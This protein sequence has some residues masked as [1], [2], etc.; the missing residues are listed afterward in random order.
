VQHQAEAVR[1][2]PQNRLFF[3]TIADQMPVDHKARTDLRSALISY[4]TVRNQRHITVRTSDP[5]R[6]HKK[7]EP[8]GFPPGSFVFVLNP[9]CL[10]HRWACAANQVVLVDVDHFFG[11]I[12]M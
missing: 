1:V 10:V 8:G 7:K 2:P 5:A 12:D 3:S 9:R 11:M 6:D 4:M